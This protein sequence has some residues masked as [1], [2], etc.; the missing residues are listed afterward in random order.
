MARGSKIF[1]GANVFLF[2]SENYWAGVLFGPWG[3]S[4]RCEYNF[5]R[6]FV[7]VSQGV[8]AVSSDLSKI[9]QPVQKNMVA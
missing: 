6:N 1:V 8:F 7:W 9:F 4:D 5:E 3:N 2:N